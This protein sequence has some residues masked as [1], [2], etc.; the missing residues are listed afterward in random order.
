MARSQLFA[1]KPMSMLYEEM[2]SESRLRRCLGPVQLSAL[3]VGAVI[4]TG[5]FVLTGVAAHDKTGPALMLS[6]VVAGMACIFAAL[7]Y[8]EFASM[9]PVAGSAYTYAYVTLGEFFAWIIGWD[10]ILEYAVASMTVAHGWSKNFQDIIGGRRRRDTEGVEQRALRL[11]PGAGPP[12]QHGQHHRPARR[13]HRHRGHHRARHRHPGERGRQHRH[14]RPQGGHRAL[15]DR[16]GRV[17]REPRQLAP[18]RPLRPH[19]AELLRKD[20][21]GPDGRGR[22]AAGHALGGGRHLLRLHRVRLR[23]HPRR[24]GQEPAEGRAHRHHRLPRPVHDPLHRRLRGA[25]GHGAVQRDQHRDP[26]VRRLPPGRPALGALPDQRGRGRGYHLGPPR[27][28]AEPAARMAGHGP[29][30]HGA[31]ELLRGRAPEVPAPPG[32]RPS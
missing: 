12:G 13:P 3:G 16:G 23:L 20:A 10:L 19:R 24:G 31:G 4:G 21:V 15:R 9:A 11:R 32:R 30:R 17:L 25:H 5:I 22:R 7:C 28:D 6:F 1:R 18:L 14:R 29:R 27:H 26:G 8:A 2:Q